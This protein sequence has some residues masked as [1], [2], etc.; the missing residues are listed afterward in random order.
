MPLPRLRDG[1]FVVV[2]GVW[3]ISD[4]CC[5]CVDCVANYNLGTWSTDC[6]EDE[7]CRGEL[8]G[9]HC[10]KGFWGL[11][12]SGCVCIAGL[13]DETWVVDADNEDYADAPPHVWST[14]TKCCDYAAWRQEQNPDDY[15]PP[16][17]ICED[18]PP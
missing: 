13:P 11:D 8:E 5:P 2:D 18:L 10:R 6:A 1:L 7:C 3:S 14:R 4:A 9:D 12:V 16:S 15:Y 17:W